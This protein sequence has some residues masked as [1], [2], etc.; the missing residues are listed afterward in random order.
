MKRRLV[1]EHPKVRFSADGK[2]LLISWEQ[3]RTTDISVHGR[4]RDTP[5]KITFGTWSRPLLDGAGPES[6]APRE[7]VGGC[8]NSQRSVPTMWAT[9]WRSMG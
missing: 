7:P 5:A 2:R 4:A 1:S 9:R 6:T 8:A 3:N